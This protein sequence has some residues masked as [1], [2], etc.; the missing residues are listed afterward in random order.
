MNMLISLKPRQAAGPDRI[1]PLVLK[2]GHGNVSTLTSLFKDG[3]VTVPK[4]WR[5][6][7]FIH[8][9]TRVTNNWTNDRLVPLTVICCKVLEYIVSVLNLWDAVYFHPPDVAKPAK[10]PLT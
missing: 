2:A 10:T 1:I 9:L 7:L 8:V 5:T 4:Q 6:V 3:T